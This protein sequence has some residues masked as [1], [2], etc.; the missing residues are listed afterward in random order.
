MDVEDVI[1]FG[2]LVEEETALMPGIFRSSSLNTGIIVISFSSLTFSVSMCS[3]LKPMSLFCTK[4]I[5]LVRM[6]VDVIKMPEMENWIM[7]RAYRKNAP[8]V[9][10]ERLPLSAVAGLWEDT[11]NAG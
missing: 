5:C 6:S 11:M 8:L 4:A 2:R 9:D 3:L 10:L 7:T 1:L